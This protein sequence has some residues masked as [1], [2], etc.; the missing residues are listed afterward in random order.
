M[1]ASTHANR[2]ILGRIFRSLGE[3]YYKYNIHFVC[4]KTIILMDIC[5]GPDALNH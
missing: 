5:L 1:V 3:L 2:A 4:D